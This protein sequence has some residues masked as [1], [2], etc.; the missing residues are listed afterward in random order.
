MSECVL[1]LDKQVFQHLDAVWHCTSSV[2]CVLTLC[3]FWIR[4]V[5]GSPL[6]ARSWRFCPRWR[7]PCWDALTSARKNPSRWELIRCHSLI[8]SNWI[9]Y[10]WWCDC[11]L[12]R[13]LRCWSTTLRTWC[14]QWRR[15]W[16]RPRQPPLKS[17]QTQASLY[18]GSERPPGTSK[19]TVF[20]IMLAFLEH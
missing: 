10:K 17:V 11:A 5:S 18:A 20:S 13:L 9:L 12:W 6:S 4:C 16:E 2:L 7:P 14:S 15:R 19:A 1:V 8:I 3:A